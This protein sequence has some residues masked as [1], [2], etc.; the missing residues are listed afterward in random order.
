MPTRSHLTQAA[1]QLKKDLNGRAFRTIQRTDVT[2]LVREISGEDTTRIKSNMAEELEKA[3][4]EQGVRTYPSLV[5][6]TTGDTIR[7]F[8]AGTLL[9]TLLDILTHPSEDDDDE[10]ARVLTKVKGKWVAPVGPPSAAVIA[11]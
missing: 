7:L 10:L 3:L 8:H 5:G 11:E 9:G 2:Q 4:L 1:R 6:T